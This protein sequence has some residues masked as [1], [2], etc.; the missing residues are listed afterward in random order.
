MDFRS[1]ALY[2]FVQVHS[3][4]ETGAT[5][6]LTYPARAI[7]SDP[8]YSPIRGRNTVRLGNR[9]IG[10][11][12]IAFTL[13]S[14]PFFWL[15]GSYG[16]SL[17]NLLA[18]F[19]GYAYFILRYRPSWF[20]LVIAL[21]ANYFAVKTINYAEYC[22]VGTLCFVGA[23]LLLRGGSHTSYLLGGA[24]L[25]LGV[26]IRL[27]TFIFGFCFL[28]F[29]GSYFLRDSVLRN[30]MALAGVGALV[31]IGS[32]FIFNA[33]DYGHFL[34]PRFLAQAEDF[35]YEAD[36]SGSLLQRQIH[37][38]LSLLF[39]NKTGVL[40]YFAYMPWLLVFAF[41]WRTDELRNANVGIA[42]AR[43]YLLFLLTF[44]LLVAA[45]APNDGWVGFGPRY[46]IMAAIGL[47]PLMDPLWKALLRSAQILR[48]GFYVLASWSVL[49]LLL[50]TAVHRF[51]STGI[52]KYQSYLDSVSPDLIVSC[53]PAVPE[54]IGSYFFK[55]PILLA[56]EE[57]TRKTSSLLDRIIASDWGGTNLLLVTEKPKIDQAGPE[58][59][60]GNP[61]HLPSSFDFRGI[62]DLKPV[63]FYRYSINRDR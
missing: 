26:W 33:W 31:V 5:E 12:P 44:V 55:Y 35:S 38:A 4:V 15:L 46:M 14:A 17:L 39:W 24:V 11:Y 25:A 30:K 7:V 21:L 23:D 41:V 1:D 27:E 13:I 9:S 58:C 32:F 59:P 49:M 61:V 50:G 48:I 10:Q 3:F 36:G 29:F 20:A 2:K 19:V 62:H 51:A 34:G 18:A 45:T 8:E 57:E 37:I 52:Q 60:P 43:R 42:H 54:F 56:D 22:L 63:R 53:T 28:V 47:F 40:G 6:E 16:L